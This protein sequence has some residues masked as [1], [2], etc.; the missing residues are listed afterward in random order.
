MDIQQLQYCA[1]LMRSALMADPISTIFGFCVWVLR[2][3]GDFTGLG[4]QLANIIV[5]IVVQPGLILLFFVL[6][7]RARR[8]ALECSSTDYSGANSHAVAW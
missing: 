5:F 6:W 7:I 8:Q 2:V 1:D 3:I 4:Y